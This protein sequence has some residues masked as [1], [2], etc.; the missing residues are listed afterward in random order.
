M[1]HWGQLPWY[2]IQFVVYN[3]C[4]FGQSLTVSNSF[5]H[6]WGIYGLITLHSHWC[7]FSI[8]RAANW[9]VTEPSGCVNRGIIFLSPSPLQENMEPMWG[10]KKKDSLS[11]TLLAYLTGRDRRGGCK[12]RIFSSPHL[13]MKATGSSLLGTRSP[14][15]I[16]SSGSLSVATIS[17]S[18]TNC[19]KNGISQ[20]KQILL[21][22]MPSSCRW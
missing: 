22:S 8:Y 6:V 13:L 5:K 11:V 20:L 17:K 9:G 14:E 2:N 19:K 7:I 10:K 4:K 16:T 18:L 21:R 1:K 3:N 15:W 12:I